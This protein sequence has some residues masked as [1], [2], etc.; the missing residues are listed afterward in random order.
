VIGM[1]VIM[2]RKVLLLEQHGID[3]TLSSS[4]SLS[5]SACRSHLASGHCC[6]REQRLAHPRRQEPHVAQKAKAPG[7]ALPQFGRAAFFQQGLEL[8]LLAH[9][10]AGVPVVGAHAVVP[11]VSAL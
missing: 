1:V 8:V 7:K 2:S 11:R 10:L 5:K 9:V 4:Q 3:K 6:R